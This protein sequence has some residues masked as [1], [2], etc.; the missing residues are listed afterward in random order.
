MVCHDMG[1][2]I[3]YLNK[4]TVSGEPTADLLI[5]HSPLHGTVIA[6]D[7]IPTLIDEIP[8]IAVLAAYADGTTIIK[9]AAEL[10]VKETNRIATVTEGLKA[11]GGKVTPTEDG[12]IIEGTGSLHGGIVNSHLDHRIAMAFSIAALAAEGETTILDSHCVDISYPS[13]YKHLS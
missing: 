4:R 2:D 6:G 3:T 11:M 5:K 13:F 8:M 1:A 7:I 12:M 10:K 9:D